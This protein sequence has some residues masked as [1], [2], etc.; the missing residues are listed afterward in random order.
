MLQRP[1]RGTET[2]PNHIRNKEAKRL[3]AYLAEWHHKAKN[4]WVADGL[5]RNH[6]LGLYTGLHRGGA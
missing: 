2:A 1:R 4:E 3:C 5:P 6:I